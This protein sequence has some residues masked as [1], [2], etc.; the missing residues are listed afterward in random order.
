MVE[1]HEGV[2]WR[3]RSGTKRCIDKRDWEGEE[4]MEFEQ[5]EKNRRE[6]EEEEEEEE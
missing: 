1:G 3:V 2:R 6:E 5:T 4:L